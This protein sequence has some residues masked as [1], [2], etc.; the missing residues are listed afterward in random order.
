MTMPDSNFADEQIDRAAYAAKEIQ[1]CIM[2]LAEY[3]AYGDRIT[4]SQV[5][6]DLVV[7]RG[8]I[9]TIVGWIDLAN[10]RAA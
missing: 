4:L 3:M 2:Q 8:N 6:R 10:T 1:S 9:D 5:R 7:A